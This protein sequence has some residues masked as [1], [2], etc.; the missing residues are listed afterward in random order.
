LLVLRLL[1]MQ[2]WHPNAAP[3]TAAFAADCSLG[4]RGSAAAAVICQTW[5]CVVPVPMDSNGLKSDV[6]AVPA[7]FPAAECA[8]P[9]GAGG[10][11]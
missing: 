9:Q 1:V 6:P 7:F 8:G 3:L 2:W 5:K 10:D 4:A 11:S